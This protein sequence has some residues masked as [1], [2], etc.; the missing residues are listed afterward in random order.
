ML[1]A[2]QA[3]ACDAGDL[4]LGYFNHGQ[5]TSASIEMKAGNSPVTAADKAVDRLLHGRLRE[6]CPE[7]AWLSEETLD[8]GARLGQNLVF[9]VD[10]IDGTRGFMAGDP[11]WCVCVALVEAGRPI[12]A[13]VH[14]PA[15]DETFIAARGQG[16]WRNGLRIQVSGQVELSGA[17]LAGPRFLLDRMAERHPGIVIARKIPSLAY[18]IALV[19]D[20]R[21]DGNIAGANSH[22]WDLAAADLILH[23]AGGVLVDHNNQT[24]QYNRHDTRHGVL[25]AG[26]RALVKQWL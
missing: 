19:A 1:A 9:V 16:A 13:V 11:Q 2:I 10:P 22:D 23:E 25:Y 12:L 20:G 26:P 21:L 3:A 17:K 14:V 18:R 5:L 6:I 24:L 7:A 4:A 15:L 8:D